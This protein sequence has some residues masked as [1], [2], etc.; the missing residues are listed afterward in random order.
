V[1]SDDLEL[2][3][4]ESRQFDA[5][6]IWQVRS[7]YLQFVEG[8]SF[9]VELGSGRGEFLAKV[10][11]GIDRV[12]GVDSEAAMVERARALGVDVVHD[13]AL[14][15]LESTDDRPDALVAAHLVEHLA[16]E[17]A[18]RLFEGA[19]R[20]LA[21][22][23][24][25]V[26]VTPNPSCLSVLLQDFW[27]DPTHVRPYT[28][29]LLQFLTRRAGL[30]VVDAGGN[31]L[32]VPGPPA[33]LPVDNVMTPWGAPSAAVEPEAR[34]TQSRLKA[35]LT[36]GVTAGVDDEVARLRRAVEL[37][38]HDMHTLAGQINT[39]GHQAAEAR[40][41]VNRTL[42]HLYGPNEIYVVARQPA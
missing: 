37:L 5:E 14:H 40:D 18:S 19:A 16:V 25:L 26:A 13:D 6:H 24:V 2:S 27:S 23:G 38:V 30:E 3:Y 15:W 11:G 4:Y 17:D 36:A 20:V 21:S 7:H 12:L 9:L 32:D 35:G 39:I 10:A 42:A 41:G 29:D 34:R 8:A 28:L 31:P 33:H 1:T 22:G